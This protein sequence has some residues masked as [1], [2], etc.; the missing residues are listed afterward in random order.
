MLPEDGVRRRLVGQWVD[1]ADQDL[2]AADVLVQ[3]VPRLAYPV[4]FHC[5]QASEKYLKAYLTYRQVEF[6]KTH[7]IRELLDL[8]ASV[9][10]ALSQDLAAAAT[11]NPYGVDARYPGDLPEP[12]E[13]DSNEALRIAHQVAEAV[14]DRMKED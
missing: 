1:K 5:Q 10:D 4:C 7:N 9:D 11:L 3:Q 8:V 6:G 2:R 12:S 14:S 13:E